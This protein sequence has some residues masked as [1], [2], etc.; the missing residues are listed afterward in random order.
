[1]RSAGKADNLI[2]IVASIVYKMW[3]PRRL[4]TMWASTVCYRDSFTF[5]FVT[6]GYRLEDCG[7]ILNKGR[8]I[9]LF[10]RAS[11]PALGHTQP[12]IQWIPGLFPRG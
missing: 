3:E 12:P 2:A 11:T 5:F 6:T 4:T 1:V 8:L 10:S 7:S 9:F